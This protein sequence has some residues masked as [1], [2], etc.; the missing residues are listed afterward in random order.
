MLYQA[1]ELKQSLGINLIHKSLDLIQKSNFVNSNW[2]HKQ[3]DS[4]TKYYI[5]KIQGYQDV[6]F[7]KITIFN[8][9]QHLN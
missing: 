6:F 2:L 3:L 1:V 5:Y 9:T 7:K 8:M 4:V